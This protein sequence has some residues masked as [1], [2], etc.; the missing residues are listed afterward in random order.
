[1]SRPLPLERIAVVGSGILGTQ[2]AMVAAYTGYAVK[3][4]DSREGAFTQTFEKIRTDLRG[5]GITPV[6][7][8]DAWD[9]CAQAVEHVT[10]LDRAVNDA[11]LVIEAVPEN[12]DLKK[13]VFK[14]LG[15]KTPHEAILATNSSSMPV[16]RFEEERQARVLPKHPFLFPS[17][18][19][20]HGR[21]YGRNADLARSSRKGLFMDSFSRVHPSYGE[22]GAPG[23]LLQSC[24]ESHQAGSALHVGKRFRGLPGCRPGM[25]GLHRDEGRAFRP[26]G[27]SGAGRGMGHRDGLLQRFQGSERPSA[28]GS[29]GKNRKG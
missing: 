10:S 20:Q 9:Q 27:Q 21:H 25:D 6:I 24:V 5:K 2:I 15:E 11:D 29:E 4:F 23:F 1:M 19:R 12:L 7:P 18:G 28:Q 3:V 8:W 22:E 16:S 13:K 17:P 26:D 14:E